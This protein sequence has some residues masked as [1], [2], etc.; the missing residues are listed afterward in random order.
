MTDSL[1]PSPAVEGVAF[2]LPEPHALDPLFSALGVTAHGSTMLDGAALR[3]RFGLNEGRATVHHHRLGSE[4]LDTITFEDCPPA[5]SLQP[6][7][8]NTL[9]FQHV[10]IVV[11]DMN[12]AAACLMPMVTPI[13]DSPQWLPNGVAAWKFRNAAGHAMELLWFPSELGHPRWH[14]SNPPL[15]QGLDHTAIAIS[16][17]DRSLAFYGCDLRLQLRYA[18]LNQGLE[19]ERL[20]GLKDARVAIHGVS[21]SSPCGVEFLR[22]LH[23]AP[24]EPTAASLQPQDALYAQILVRDPDAGHGRLL[25]DPDGHRLWIES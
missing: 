24:C 16:D 18:T 3:R 17:S 25:S 8:A 12:R 13:S 2:S 9:W 14:Q 7:P 1:R 22:Y 15:F 21:G 10:A 11:S 20:D 19:Q 6:G 4:R 23:P 5:T